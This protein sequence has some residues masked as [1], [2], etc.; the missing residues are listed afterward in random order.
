MP[1]LAETLQRAVNRRE[2]PRVPVALQGHVSISAEPSPRLVQVTNLSGGGAGLQYVGASPRAEMVGVLTVEAFGSFEGITTRG[3]G[4]TCGLRF[5]IG[6]AER[7]NLLECLT[8]FVIGGLPSVASLRRDQLRSQDLQI[9]LTRQSGQQ[10]QCKV[11]DI[12]LQGVALATS[13]QVPEGENVLVGKM[14]GRVVSGLSDQVTVQ[15]LRYVSERPA[16]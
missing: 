4:G 5:L 13:V 14:F 15:F 6:E 12:S 8:V 2:Y 9:S 11:V 16:A 10:H 1:N 3:N 7:H